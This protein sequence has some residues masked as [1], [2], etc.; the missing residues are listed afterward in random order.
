ME[1]LHC[2]LHEITCGDKQFVCSWCSKKYHNSKRLESHVI[3][4]HKKLDF[5]AVSFKCSECKKCF[6]SADVLAGHQCP[7]KETQNEQQ[8]SMFRNRGIAGAFLATSDKS[9]VTSN[10]DSVQ[11]PSSSHASQENNDLHEVESKGPRSLNKKTATAYPHLDNTD[12]DEPNSGQ[13]SD[14]TGRY[15]SS[16][17]FETPIR[18]AKGSP[19]SSWSQPSKP[20]KFS[21]K[22]LIKLQNS[23]EQVPSTNT[24]SVNSFNKVVDSSS[25]DRNYNCRNCSMVFGEQSEL[26]NHILAIHQTDRDQALACCQCNKSFYT[27]LALT[28][29]L[30]NLHKTK[31]CCTRCNLVFHDE[32]GLMAHNGIMHDD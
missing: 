10:L 26:D 15:D 13:L 19:S 2:N 28:V 8:G 27:R 16:S 29:H 32:R 6:P 21:K 5:K 4:V 11:P 22:L 1:R 12:G 30:K 17:E 18:S 9:C 3:G 25:Q 24:E 31:L 20:Y 23:K 7:R 14:D